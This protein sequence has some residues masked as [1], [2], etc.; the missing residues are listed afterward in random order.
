MSLL[1]MTRVASYNGCC[2]LW[3]IEFTRQFEGNNYDYKHSTSFQQTN[4]YMGPKL[5]HV[6]VHEPASQRWMM[7][8]MLAARWAYH[9]TDP[10]G[11]GS[12]WSQHCS[13]P[14]TVY[15]WR[16]G[17][18]NRGHTSGWHGW[19]SAL[20]CRLWV[21]APGRGSFSPVA[22]FKLC[23]WQTLTYNIRNYVYCIDMDLDS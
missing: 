15:I 17:T 5:R 12:K 6:Y 7:V 1:V 11:M 2:H 22:T 4:P 20:G 14:M 23:S 18:K 13:P 10:Q 19:S 3:W 8:H 16:L 21:Q 9:R